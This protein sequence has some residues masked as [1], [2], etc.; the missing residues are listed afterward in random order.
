[1]RSP[2]QNAGQCHVCAKRF[3]VAAAVAEEFAELLVHKSEALVVGRPTDPGVDLGPLARAD[4]RDAHDLQVR[5]S[6]AQGATLLAGAGRSPGAGHF[7]R[8]TVLADTAPGIAAFDEETFGPVAALATA[9]TD[10]ELL[11]LANGTSFGL[12][13]S[14]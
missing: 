10:A 2:F 5:R 11:D 1:V 14:V 7:Y 3:L 9:R 6:I 4:L 12:R 13:L 8:S